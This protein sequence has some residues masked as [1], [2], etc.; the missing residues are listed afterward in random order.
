[1]LRPGTL[2]PVQRNQHG[3]AFAVIL[4]ASELSVRCGKKAEAHAVIHFPC[5]PP[6]TVE[7]LPQAKLG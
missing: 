5:R 6:Q 1:M 2:D 3:V 4:L 7:L